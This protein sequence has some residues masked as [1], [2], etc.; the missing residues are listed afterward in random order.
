MNAQLTAAEKLSECLS[1]QMSVLSIETEPVK[2]QN[3]KK[4]LFD[5]IGISYDATTFSSPRQEKL[6]KSQLEISSSS[7]AGNTSFEKSQ[8]SAIK[9]SEPETARRCRNSLDKVIIYSN[10][11]F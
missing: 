11:L 1:K 2:K 4:E 10:V 7:T 9:S 3:V 5:T 8:P 6:P